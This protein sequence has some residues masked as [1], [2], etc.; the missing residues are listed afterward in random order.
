VKP[1][2]ASSDS[3][4][5][6]ASTRRPYRGINCL[7][8][9]LEAM[10]SG[11]ARSRWLTFRQAVALGAHVR[12][13]ERGCTVVFYKLR[14]VPE[15]RPEVGGSEKRIV[16]FLR[17]FTVFNV[18]QIDGLPANATPAPITASWDPDAEAEALVTACGADVRHGSSEA[19]YNRRMDAIYVPDRT[20]FHRGG[21]YYATLL[22]ELVHWTGHSERCNRDLCGRFGD[23]GY[24]MEELVAEL[25]S[26]FLCAH[27]H[28]D[29]R[30]QH[31]EYVAS[32]LEV[33]K[34]DKRAIFTA[35]T[36]AQT[37]ADFLLQPTRTEEAYAVNW[38]ALT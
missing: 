25:G 9:T 38:E 20:A 36:K 34:Q 37:A 28:I 24:A 16:P 5:M 10:I 7:L 11:Y 30:L 22:H 12:Q 6:N 1:W 4:P 17:A 23:A 19:Y 13:G 21:D 33:L 14:E 26:A 35:S 29:G 18:S 15:A 2:S 27:C 8:L 32:W 3:L 31:A